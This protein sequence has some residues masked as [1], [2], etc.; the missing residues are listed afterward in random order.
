MNSKSNSK[1]IYYART[2]VLRE[3]EE[4]RWSSKLWKGREGKLEEGQ[5]K[6]REET[7]WHDRERSSRM[8]EELLITIALH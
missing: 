3:G 4:R 6:K 1:V 7:M 8:H 5:T 2:T